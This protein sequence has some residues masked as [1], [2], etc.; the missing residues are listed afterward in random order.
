MDGVTRHRD[1]RGGAAGARGGNAGAA[2]LPDESRGCCGVRA[3][4]AGHWGIEEENRELKK[5]VAGLTLDQYYVR[6]L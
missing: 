3:G 1:G 2:L 4:G 6:T 5:I